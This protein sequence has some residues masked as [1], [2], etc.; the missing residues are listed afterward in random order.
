[1]CAEKE[2]WYVLQLLS[3]G[4]GTAPEAPMHPHVLG[5]YRV[6]QSSAQVPRVISDIEWH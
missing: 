2:V 4:H 3:D 1:M 6:V 5:V